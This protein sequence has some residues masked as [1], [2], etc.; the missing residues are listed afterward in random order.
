MDNERGHRRRAGGERRVEVLRVA[1]A[2]LAE[3][4]YDR[5]RFSDVAS[6]A[7]V[8]VSTLQFYFGSR[9]D[10]LVAA[11]HH[12]TEE[13]VRVMERCAAQEDGPWER[14]LRLLERGLASQPEQTWRMLLEFWYAAVRD[15]ELR[16]HSADLQRRYRRPFV[17]AVHEGVRTGRFTTDQDPEDLVTVVLA[18]LDGMVVPRLCAHDYVREEQVRVI[19]VDA[20]A[21]L[22]GVDRSTT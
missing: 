15:P 19:A 4:G 10:M 7:G 5:T 16:A 13:E 21:G 1:A 2:V 22:L 14:L 12:S 17:E 6:A 18:L 20:V 3:R 9:D 8:A 11:L